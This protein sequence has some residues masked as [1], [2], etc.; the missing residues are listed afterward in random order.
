MKHKNIIFSIGIAVLLSSC[1]E[2]NHKK[3]NYTQWVNPFI[4]TLH[5]GHCF[6]GA[7]IPLG[8]VQVSPESYNEYYIGY[9]MD[10]V[11]GYQY[12]DPWIWGFTQT[13][14]SGAGCPSYS[15]ILLMPADKEKI[16]S[17]RREDFKSRYDKESESA[18]PGYYTV[19]LIDPAVKVEL[20]ATEH[21]AY[22]RYIYEKPASASMVVDLQYG[23]SWDINSIY[24]NII[25]A[26]QQV[27]DDYTITGYR[28]TRVWASRKLFYV[29]RFNKKIKNSQELPAPDGKAEEAPRYLL[30]FDMQNKDDLEVMIGLSTTSIDAA[31]K[32]MEAQTTGWKTFDKIRAQAN[33]MWNEKLSKISI[34]GTDEQRINFYTS[35]YQLYIQPNNY[36]DVSGTYRASNDSIV[37]SATGKYYSSFALWDTHRAANPLYTILSPD[38][39]S[40]VITSLMDSYTYK[41]VDKNNPKEAN[42]YLPR[43]PI[44]GVE[45]HT[46]I[47]NHAVAVIADAWEK[48]IK[49]KVYDDSQVYEALWTSTTKPHFR[50]HVELIDEYGY[51]PYDVSKSSI[52]DQMET[53]SRLLEGT[54][55]DYCV[56]RIA[57]KLGKKDDAEFLYN[58]A[59]FYKN[60]FDKESG[61]M[62]G[63][64]AKGKFKPV[65]D[66]NE[67][68]GEWI[69]QSDFTEGNAWHYLFHV[70]HDIPGLK[71]LM[72]EDLFV[73]RL[74]TM[75]FTKSKPYVA[76]IAWNIYGTVGQYWHGNEPCHHVPYL[77]KYT[78]YPQKSDAMLRF[79]VKYFHRNAPDGL[80]GNIDCGQMPAW[81]ILSSLGFY[82]VN[83]CGGNY[84]LGA[85][86]L[87]SA[88]INL[89]NG[90]KFKVIAENISDE[91]YVVDEVLLN[92]IVLDRNYITHQEIVEG[93][94]LRFKMIPDSENLLEIIKANAHEK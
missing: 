80:K 71:D 45:T 81:Y 9:E 10:H 67:I 41:P 57:E 32:N 59:G 86:Q 64:N 29:I 88:T 25:E 30:D 48:G 38:L 87:P 34:E 90:K 14:L 8:M 44:W 53:V 46:M 42:K 39:T 47:G 13:H 21:V 84:T 5:E 24:Q 73:S 89:P 26:S 2:E 52:D 1:S 17:T 31:K 60:V 19:N 76:N 74:D 37:K 54:F 12:N 20:T 33:D 68:V 6:P 27:E 58:R 40:D 65:K 18:M 78:S 23:V 66:L 92:N 61:F 3:E 82:S 93:G 51:I 49:S 28:Y 22:H 85:P 75:I 72:G 63:R 94:E 35:M 43:L 69:F 50:N 83:P 11:A 16:S 36:A 55:D 62:R 15:D 70:Q 7:T 79:L 91:N 77:Y 4:G 56:A